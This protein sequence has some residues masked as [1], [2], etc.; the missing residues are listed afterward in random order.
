[1]LVA[2]IAFGLNG[3]FSNALLIDGTLSPWLHMACRFGTACILFWLTS[4]VSDCRSG[5]VMEM[6]KAK[7]P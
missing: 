6:A 3:P 2:T 4:L 5:V 1:M 7:S